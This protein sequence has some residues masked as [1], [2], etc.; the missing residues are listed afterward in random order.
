MAME[1]VDGQSLS[2]VLARERLPRDRVVAIGLELVGALGA[3]HGNDIVHGDLKPA[4]IA[5]TNEG[6]AKVLDFGVARAVRAASGT[7]TTV[8]PGPVAQTLTAVAGTPGYMSP[9]QLHGERID[10]RSDLYSLGVVMFEMATGRRPYLEITIEELREAVKQPAPRADSVARGVPRWLAD[11]IA[12]SLEPQK[13]ARFQSA[14]E[15]KQALEAVQQH[16]KELGRRELIQRWLTRIAVGVP[17]LILALEAVGLTNAAGFNWT[18]GRTGAYA[19]FGAESWMASFSS[20]VRAVIGSLAFATLA[21]VVVS[22]LSAVFRA[23]E[24]T[25]PVR[26]LAQRLR[27][28]ARALHVGMGLSRP[29]GLAQ[30]LA[31]LALVTL[32]VFVQIYR[33]LI[34]AWASSFNDSPIA[35]LLPIG[36]GQPAR[37]HYNWFLDVTI[38]LFILG[39]Y[40]AV[41]L[42]RREGSRDGTAALAVLAGVIAMMLFMREWPQR[43]FNRRDLEVVEFDGA[44]CYQNGESGD[45]LLVLCPAGAPPRNH[46]LKRDDPRLKRNGTRENVFRGVASVLR[47][48]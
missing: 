42:R 3:A 23:A 14:A 4:N 18:F 33:D 21:A 34:T 37:V 17:L 13:I 20:G 38:P 29:Q 35:N 7:T 31:G 16:V 32:L 12:K 45:E 48:P 40:R 41:R 11:F 19:K 2:T 25:A 30:A 47:E 10:G 36:E 28:R 26:R 24:A 46:V 39:L 27:T 9:E 8:G 1:Y 6:S 22:G 5:L 44:H 15:M 43:T